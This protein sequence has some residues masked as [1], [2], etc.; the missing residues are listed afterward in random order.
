M[1]STADKSWKVEALL[2]LG[3]GL[4]FSLSW[5]GLLSYAAGRFLPNLTPGDDRFVQFVIGTTSLQGAALILVHF[6]L[7]H[8]GVTWRRFLGLDRPALGHIVLRALAVAALA[9]PLVLLLAAGCEQVLRAWQGDVETQAAVK[10]MELALS[11]GRRTLFLLASL[12]LAPV[13]EEILF[14]GILYPAIKQQGHPRLA[15]A[16]SA[17][18]FS[19]IHFN[20]LAFIPFI[21]LAVLLTLLY[22]RT[23]SLLAPI[24][25]HAAFNAANVIYFAVRQSAAA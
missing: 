9:T 3:A 25:A 6:F 22:E 23:G 15:L 16:A 19:A 11:P 8:H 4:L 7:R 12:V 5:G 18:L 1:S 20:Q 2:L 21:V 10:V 17:V 14:R 24:L 13:A